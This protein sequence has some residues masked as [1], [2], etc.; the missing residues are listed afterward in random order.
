MWYK[1]AQCAWKVY[2]TPFLRQFFFILPIF[3]SNHKNILATLMSINQFLSVSFL[4]CHHFVQV[5]L[6][7]C[8]KLQFF[9]VTTFPK[10]DT[11]EQIAPFFF[12]ASFSPGRRKT[13]TEEEL[14]EFEMQAECVR[15][16][17]PQVLNA[18]QGETPTS[19]KTVCIKINIA[20]SL[21]LIINTPF[22]S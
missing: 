20:M 8:V 21:F 3:F 10:Q 18:D 4:I 5:L 15:F 14:K 9:W 11:G 1:M 13:I 19:G 12:Y 22:L 2:N 16:S 7:Y 17:K 6:H